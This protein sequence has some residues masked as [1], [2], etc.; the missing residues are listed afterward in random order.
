MRVL[1]LRGVHPR[2]MS[3]PKPRP[4]SDSE[5]ILSILVILSLCMPKVLSLCLY[6]NEQVVQGNFT[7]S[8]FYPYVYTTMNR[9]YREISHTF[10]SQ[11]VLIRSYTI[12]T[13]RINISLPFGL[14]VTWKYT[15]TLTLP[16][17][18]PNPLTPPGWPA[19]HLK[20]W[21]TLI[22]KPLKQS[23]RSPLTKGY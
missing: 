3:E 18:P 12:M 11:M 2:Y 21:A 22:L 10:I 16:V 14:T 23:G 9:S 6:D 13:F 19:R 15:W 5:F 20:L 1:R 8:K 17:P 7:D 4:I